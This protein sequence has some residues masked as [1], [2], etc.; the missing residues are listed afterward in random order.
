MLKHAF[1]MN[2]HTNFEQVKL[3]VDSLQFGDVYIHV[4]KKNEGLY[5]KIQ[6]EYG[7]K[8]NIFLV[9]DRV[10]VNWSGFSQVEATLRLLY[11]VNKTG[12]TYNYIHFISGQ[13][14]LVLSQYELDEYL[15]KNGLDKQYVE[16][17]EIGAYKWRLLCYSFFRENKNNRKLYYR[18]LDNLIRLPQLLLIKRHTFDDMTLYKGSSWFSITYDCLLYILDYLQNNRYIDR[19]KYTACSD[20]HFFQILLMNSKYRDNVMG[21]NGRYII[22]EGLNAS[23]KILDESD[24]LEFTNGE[25]MFARKFNYDFAKSTLKKLKERHC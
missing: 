9:R 20:E 4:D 12:R 25:F 15:M 6:E 23:P 1:I 24:F 14:L 13:D 17:E 19:F 2:V 11:L 5:H 7:D 16:V 22:F 10:Y 18:I 8:N 21:K 3:V